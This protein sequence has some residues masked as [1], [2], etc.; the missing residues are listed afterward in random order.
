MTTDTEEVRL[1][2]PAVGDRVE[3][4]CPLLKWWI[5][6]DIHE[7]LLRI[8]LPPSGFR[9][10]YGP[11]RRASSTHRRHLGAIGKDSVMQL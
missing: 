11:L 10:P 2:W 4:V 7:K 6:N 1:V 9:I 3:S 8:A 5:T